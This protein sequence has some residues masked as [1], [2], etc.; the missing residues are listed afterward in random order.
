[1]VALVGCS[2]GKSPDNDYLWL[3]PDVQEKVQKSSKESELSRPQVEFTNGNTVSNCEEYF[4]Q[5]GGFTETAANYTARSHYL[6][7]DA[8]KLAETWPPKSGGKPLDQDLSLCSSLNLASFK[9][10]LRPR[11]ETENATLT[12]LFGAEAVDGVNTCT[13]Q[14]EGRNL[15]LNAVLLVKEPEKPK[16]MWVW[17]IDEIL[18]ATYRSYEP[19][20]FVFDESK[21][22]WIATQ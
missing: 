22:M 10:S 21:S 13:F 6:I 7:C 9:H 4:L 3:D 1:M 2:S 19:V 12:Q 11:I 18:E 14:G 8:L 5:E 20:W 16:K 15:V 17:V